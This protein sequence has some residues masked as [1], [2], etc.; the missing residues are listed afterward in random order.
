MAASIRGRHT[1]RQ[2]TPSGR[3]PRLVS[4]WALTAKEGST[5]AKLEVAYMKALESVD[6][7]E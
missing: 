7:I 6:Q 4:P 1:I 3:E 2:N 5:L